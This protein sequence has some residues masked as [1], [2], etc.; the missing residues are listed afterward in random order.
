[1]K[2]SPGE[3]TKYDYTLP[4]IRYKLSK[5]YFIY[6]K[7]RKSMLDFG[8]GNGANTVLFRNDFNKIAGIDID[9]NFIKEACDH[10]KRK[11]ISNISYRVFNG[12]H[13][14]FANEIFDFITCFEVLEH[15][16][17]DDR[18]LQE[19]ARLLNKEGLLCLSVPNK[20]YIMETH[21]FRL[22]LNKYIKWNRVPFM[23]FLPK[24][25]YNRYGKARIY[26]KKEII[27][28]L[29]KNHLQVIE[30]GYLKPPLDKL[31]ASPIIKTI[32]KSIIQL[33]PEW[34]G[35][36]IFIAAKKDE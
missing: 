6:L 22:P 1:M 33:L 23:N 36:S 10:S 24:S 9:K 14:S 13:T 8:C 4:H 18:A 17:D 25:F 2:I 19:I 31:H 15:T 7:N 30:A 28:L 20:L 34:M 21:G 12:K 11:K 5:E 32:V 3:P 16:F 27:H 29:H 35:I 26:T